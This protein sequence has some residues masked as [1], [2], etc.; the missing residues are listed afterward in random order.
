LTSRIGDAIV[1]SYHTSKSLSERKGGDIQGK[2]KKAFRGRKI[3]M[4]V[5]I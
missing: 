1:V 3:H 5:Q 4:E 2:S